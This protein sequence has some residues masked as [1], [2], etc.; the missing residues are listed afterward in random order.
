MT[1]LL[2][3]PPQGEGITASIISPRTILFPF[4]IGLWVLAWSLRFCRR[5]PQLRWRCFPWLKVLLI[6]RCLE[7]LSET[8]FMRTRSRVRKRFVNIQGG[9]D[10]GERSLIDTQNT[11]ETSTRAR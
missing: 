1:Q 7:N 10:A 11:G 2:A 9:Q 3:P 8:G 5:L 4:A 6:N